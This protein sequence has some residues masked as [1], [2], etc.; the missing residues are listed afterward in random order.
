MYLRSLT[1]KGFK[2]FA[3]RSVISFE[4]GLSAIVGPNGSGKSNIAEAVLWV[5]GEQ[6]TSNLRIQTMEELIF[7]G[8]SARDP[9]GVAE[10]ELVLDNAD[11]TLPIE[12]EQVAISRRMHRNGESEYYIN[13]APTR[14][15]DIIDILFDSGIGHG[16]HSVIGQGNL[17]A[18][19]ESR[20]ED[21]R[22]LIEEAAGILKHK[23]RKEKSAR[24][25][26]AMDASLARVND[27]IQVTES[28][29]KPL[30]RQAARA[31]QYRE[32]ADEL[33]VLELSLAVDD[34]RS[35]RVDWNLID[36]N[37]RE[38]QAEAEL[39]HFRLNE[40]EAELT[41]RQRILE[42]KG[43]FVGDLNEQRIR[44]QSIIQRLDA[45]ML[46]LEEKGKNLVSRLSDLRANLHG[47]IGRLGE[48]RHEHDEISE[49]LAEGQAQHRALAAELNELMRAS[50][51][52]VKQRKLAEE[53]Y[54]SLLSGQRSKQSALDSTE[55]SLAKAQES[56]GAL[57]VEEG[58]LNDQ[59]KQLDSDIASTQAMLA[60][61]RGKL[62]HLTAALRSEQAES[63]QAKAEVDKRVRLQ[64]DRQKQLLGLREQMSAIQ[65]ETRALEEVDRAFESASP[66]LNWIKQQSGRFSG[67]VSQ[68]SESLKVKSG[69]EL[70]HGLST[71][72]LEAL[73]ERLLGT[74]L[75]GLLVQDASAA[76]LIAE[77]L[78]NE[79][80][81]KG[82]ISLLPIEHS[83]PLAGA[84]KSGTRLFDLLEYPPG[85]A[86]AIEA[87]IGDVYLVGSLGEAQKYQLRDQSGARFATP[88][89]AVVWPNGK[90]TVGVQLSNIDSVL[91]RRRRQ[92]SL[93]VELKASAV[94]VSEAEIE[95]SHADK[96]LEAAQAAD[97]ELSQSLAKQSGDSDALR[98]EVGRVEES[99]SQLLYKKEGM[100]SRL[101]DVAARRLASLPLTGEFEKRISE[102][103]AQLEAGEGLVAEAKEQLD[104][105]QA[106]RLGTGE[107]LAEGRLRFESA[108]GT[109]QFLDTRQTALAKEI[110]T[111]EQNIEVYSQS[112]RSLDIIRHRVDPLYQLYKDL[113]G[114]ASVWAEKL[115]DQAQLEQSDSKNLREVI[116]QASTAVEEARAE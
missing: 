30:E 96:N 13:G 82:E 110:G 85:Q 48:A 35:L 95:L 112:E 43:L 78:I 5:L 36:R 41:K 33:K 23:R 15:M 77:A 54:D 67:I 111:L 31:K 93:A 19:L 50:E 94:Q 91:E 28:Q 69:A 6:K 113:H 34:L 105:A 16:V 49:R 7:S 59:A 58:L 90:V 98:E 11:G 24:K 55:L 88:A 86:A 32:L 37:E 87:M 99:L 57:D 47:S 73:V 97:L 44:C 75:Y 39:I 2:S 45:G 64:S 60:E 89:G 107:R 53:G 14:R 83:R 26:D 61:R 22:D 92:E 103:K 29:L 18:V 51:Q 8:S 62:E 114:G 40:R 38:V 25:L 4:P 66:A 71:A 108:S 104:R 52:A 68:V 17:T 46:V 72:Q 101:A 9:V 20:P 56:L 81:E 115:R 12:Y 80:S 1:I 100:E 3:D 27:I 65:A 76:R 74:D 70:P 79:S 10:V 21:R 109:A 84:A 63:K 102:L 106:E 116:T 42:E